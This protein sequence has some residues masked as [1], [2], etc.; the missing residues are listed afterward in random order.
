M[1]RETA[2]ELVQRNAMKSWDE[3][4]DFRDLI[5]SDPEAAGR[6]SEGQLDELFDYAHFVRYVDHVYRR[7]GLA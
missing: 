7:V 3:G 2:Y 5:R 4:V 6:I 1:S